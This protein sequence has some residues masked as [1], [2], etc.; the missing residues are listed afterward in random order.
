M[1]KEFKVLQVNVRKMSEAQHSMMNDDSLEDFSLLLVSE[2]YLFHDRD[3]KY[4]VAPQSHPYWTL[5]LP[6]HTKEDLRP[7]AML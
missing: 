1:S 5:Y 6:K 2:P 3:R 4:R 7:R